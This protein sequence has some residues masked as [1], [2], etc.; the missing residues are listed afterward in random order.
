MNY[1]KWVGNK[2]FAI[3]NYKKEWREVGNKPM[4]TLFENGGRKRNGDKCFDIT[5]IIRYTVFNYT[6]FDLQGAMK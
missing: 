6:N 3:R 4:L 1:E 5:L 2:V